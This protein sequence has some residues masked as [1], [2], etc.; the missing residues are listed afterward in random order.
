M[1]KEDF[2]ELLVKIDDLLLDIDYWRQQI[3]N[4]QECQGW[5]AQD[6]HQM[7][8]ACQ[9]ALQKQMEA[10]KKIS[11]STEMR[12]NMIALKE[13]LEEDTTGELTEIF[14]MSRQKHYE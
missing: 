2:G 13:A 3:T 11:S 8:P 9:E 12:N 10:L 4:C 7:C 1:N 6:H 5:A 14:R